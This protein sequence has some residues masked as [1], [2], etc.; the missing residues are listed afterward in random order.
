[1]SKNLGN[2]L[3][4]KTT[5]LLGYNNSRRRNSAIFLLTVDSESYPHVALL[6]PYQV[7]SINPERLL[8]AVHS[9]S[10][11]CAFLISE[12][13]GTLILQLP[14]AVQYVRCNFVVADEEGYT[15][16]SLG[17]RLFYATVQE[18][19]E[20]YSKLAPLTSE[21]LFDETNTYAQYSE[22]F[23]RLRRISEKQP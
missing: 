23:N 1:M 17:E 16:E 15:D 11:S 5:S 14:P 3:P 21:L 13:R 12:G 9:T 8:V 18:V 10:R 7:V 19:L 2:H 22:G 20:D 4:V 6:S